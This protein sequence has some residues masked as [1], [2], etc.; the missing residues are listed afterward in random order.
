MRDDC[1]Q[2]LGNCVCKNEV[3][4]QHC[5]ICPTGKVMTSTG[6]KEGK[7]HGLFVFTVLWGISEEI[8]QVC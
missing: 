1:E 2:M 7:G 5:D 6:C 8:H 4:G 3:S